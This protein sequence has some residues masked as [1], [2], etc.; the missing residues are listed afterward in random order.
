MGGRRAGFERGVQREE[1]AELESR[2]KTGL[3]PYG[4]NQGVLAAVH[5]FPGT[6]CQMKQ[7]PP[8]VAGTAVEL[9]R[10]IRDRLQVGE[11]LLGRLDAAEDVLAAIPKTPRGTLSLDEFER[12]AEI[13]RLVLP[14]E[15]AYWAWY[16][17]TR[18]VL[19][20]FFGARGKELF[21]NAEAPSLPARMRETDIPILRKLISVRVGELRSVSQRMGAGTTRQV[22][23]SAP[24]ELDFL[25]STPI[26][27]AEVVD[28]LEK[29]IG[30]IRDRRNA[31]TVRLVAPKNLLKP[32]AMVHSSGW[33]LNRRRPTT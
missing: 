30:S 32:S 28:D 20:Q 16:R 21:G 9:R 14:T 33:G 2:D 1:I 3:D 11:G 19:E 24:T 13:D 18:G 17:S 22:H 5:P 31:R 25:R 23:R 7:L 10:R 26:V 6:L 8:L 15:R 27:E 12:V 29:R 4:I